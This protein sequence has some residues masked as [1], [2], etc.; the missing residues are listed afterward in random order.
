VMSGMAVLVEDD[1]VAA[2]ELQEFTT[3]IMGR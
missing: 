1:H 2:A 3:W